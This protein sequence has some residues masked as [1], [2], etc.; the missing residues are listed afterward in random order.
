MDIKEVVNN[1]EWQ[2][3]REKMVGTWKVDAKKNCQ[4]LRKYLDDFSDRLKIRRVHNYLTGS[5]FRIGIIQDPEITKLVNEIRN[6]KQL[7]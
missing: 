5:R 7:P 2:S 6:I 3:I 4:I 1:S